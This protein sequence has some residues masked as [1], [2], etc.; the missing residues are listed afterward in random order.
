VWIGVIV[1]FFSLSQ[2]KQDLYVLPIV[3]AVAA[4]VAVAV[5]RAI[6]DRAWAG[7]LRWTAIVAAMLWTAAG[8]AVAVLFTAAGDIYEL[9]GAGVVGALAMAGGAGGLVLA[10]RR[11]AGA[12]LGLIAATL[13]A[14]NWTIVTVTLPDFERY[15]PVRPFAALVRQIA[16]DDALVGYYRFAVPSLAFYMRR[17][18]F[19][20]LGPDQLRAALESGRPVYCLVTEHDLAE[21]RP[22]LPEPLYILASR[23]IFDVKL[24]S[25]IARQPLP[26]MLLVS[27]RP[28]R[29]AA[30]L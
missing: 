4:L 11:R 3:P 10:A 16:P 22:S 6:A 27:N 20:Y 9:A 23:P 19:E 15:K 21:V 24:E 2:N 30:P 12:A 17:P 13:V 5:E 29:P 25:V 28:E 14:A 1:G 26:R 7:A 8:L 18:V